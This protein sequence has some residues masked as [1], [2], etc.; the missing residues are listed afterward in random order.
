MAYLMKVLINILI[1]IKAVFV[2]LALP[3][4]YIYVPIK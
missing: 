3:I 2:A 1:T 4:P